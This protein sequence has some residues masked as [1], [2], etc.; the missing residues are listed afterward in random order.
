MLLDARRAYGNLE[1]SEI[2]AKKLASWSQLSTLTLL[3][4]IC[5]QRW[6]NG[7]MLRLRQIMGSSSNSI[8]YD[9]PALP[10]PLNSTPC[11]VTAI[12]PHF[13]LSFRHYERG[14]LD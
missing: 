3:C 7:M 12:L 10:Q 14:P 8:F 11:I 13:R 5:M 2:G 1:C 9:Q 4:S 6:G